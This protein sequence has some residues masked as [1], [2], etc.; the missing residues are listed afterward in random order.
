[1]LAKLLASCDI[2]QMIELFRTND[3]V[4]I[5]F[6]EA[7]LR[8]SG[9]AHF[10]ADQHMS[11]LDG[12]IGILP[13]RMMVDADEEDRARRLMRDAGLEDQLK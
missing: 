12:S 10:V 11:I 8:D 1:M 5:S 4:L 13:R 6:A 3:A 7:L 2:G 9:I